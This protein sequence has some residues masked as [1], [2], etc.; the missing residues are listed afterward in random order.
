MPSR[1]TRVLGVDF[2]WS[3]ATLWRSLFGLAGRQLDALAVTHQ[4]RNG[5]TRVTLRSDPATLRPMAHAATTEAQLRELDLAIDTVVS[6]PDAA[7]L[8]RLLAD[9]FVYT[10]AGGKPEPKREFI[11]TAVARTDPPRRILHDRWSHTA[12][13]R[14][15]AAPSSSSTAILDP[16]CIWDTCACTAC[17][18]TSGGRSRI[19]ASTCSIAAEGVST[20]GL[21]QRLGSCYKWHRRPDVYSSWALF[22]SP[23]LSNDE[24]TISGSPLAQPI[25]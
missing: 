12:T 19:A 20:Q 11:A 6:G 8:E 17:S 1:V 15:P 7:T 16:T 5:H 2:E 13:S 3:Q 23:Q 24:E 9:D 14:S 4:A 22:C 10:H 18:A 25:A 21:A